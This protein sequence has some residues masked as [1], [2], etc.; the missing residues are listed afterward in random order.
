MNTTKWSIT[1]SQ[2]LAGQSARA[3]DVP[4]TVQNLDEPTPVKSSFSS[5]RG[6]DVRKMVEDAA[7]IREQKANANKTS[8]LSEIRFIEPTELFNKRTSGR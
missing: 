3:V 8:E 5:S 7:I 2:Q 4:V 6:I 1:R